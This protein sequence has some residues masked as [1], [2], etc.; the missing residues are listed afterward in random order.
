MK[1]TSLQ[2]QIIGIQGPDTYVRHP[3][4]YN[5]QRIRA[6]AADIAK[7]TKEVEEI[8][9]K[10]LRIVEA[11]SQHQFSAGIQESREIVGGATTF[12]FARAQVDPNTWTQSFMSVPCLTSARRRGYESAVIRNTSCESM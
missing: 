10:T 4:C 11:E 8:H 5:V 1:R 12:S 9:T 7:C 3:E 6:M 2:G